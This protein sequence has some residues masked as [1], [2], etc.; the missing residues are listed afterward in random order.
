MLMMT[1]TI[2]SPQWLC[3]PFAMMSPAVADITET[4]YNFT[5]Q[6]PWV[7]SVDAERAWRWIDNFLIL[8]RLLHRRGRTSSLRLLHQVAGRLIR[9]LQVCTGGEPSRSF[10]GTPYED[11]VP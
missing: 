9:K 6:P 8:V 2:I 7:G 10:G 1:M 5:L 3:V 11:I 4:A